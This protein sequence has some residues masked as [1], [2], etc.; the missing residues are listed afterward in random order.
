LENCQDF[1]RPRI[2]QI[3][4]VGERRNNPN[5]CFLFL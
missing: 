5:E 1:P 4:L 3:L 2:T